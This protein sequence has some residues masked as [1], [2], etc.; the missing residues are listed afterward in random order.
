MEP[1]S[2]VEQLITLNKNI[3]KGA[4]ASRSDPGGSR[5]RESFT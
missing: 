3:L 2:E 1:S 5:R 4:H